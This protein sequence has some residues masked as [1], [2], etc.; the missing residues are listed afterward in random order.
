MRNSRADRVSKLR[1]QTQVEGAGTKCKLLL[2]NLRRQTNRI[3]A[4]LFLNNHQ[5]RAVFD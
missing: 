4:E 3:F 2:S 1:Q 5:G